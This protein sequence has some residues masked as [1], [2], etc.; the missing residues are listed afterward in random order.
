MPKKR[1]FL[2]SSLLGTKR[3]GQEM[4]RGKECK[5]VG[6]AF[7]RICFWVVVKTMVPFWVLNITRHLIFNGPKRGP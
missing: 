7:G 4:A 6:S 5:E 1:G 2:I 3:Q